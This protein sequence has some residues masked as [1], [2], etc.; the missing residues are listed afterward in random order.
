MINM[1]RVGDGIPA[2]GRSGGTRREDGM[3]GML[4]EERSDETR[5]DVRS[6]SK[7][8]E[9]LGKKERDETRLSTKSASLIQVKL[10]RL[11]GITKE[12]ISLA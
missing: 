6:E 7:C 4:N 10:D 1:K 3:G 2:G 11:V 5:S 8:P 9:D 12:V